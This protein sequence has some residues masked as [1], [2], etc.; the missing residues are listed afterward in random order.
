MGA[1]LQYAKVIDR[2][3]FFS[4]G[5]RVQPGLPNEI[6]LHDEPGRAG[7]FLVLRGWC[8]DHGTFTEQ[9]RIESPG[10][11]VVYE[12]SP[13]EVH[14][15]TKAHVEKLQDEVADLDLQYSA[16]DYRV[17]FTLDDRE[18]ARTDFAVRLDGRTQNP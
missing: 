15:A 10:G 18:V 13:R 8:D 5:G 9:W 14:L 4:R 2:E 7:A 16:D 17:V 6:M 3:I 11:G 1:K 12:S